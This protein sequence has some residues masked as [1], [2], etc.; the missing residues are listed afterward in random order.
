VLNLLAGV[1]QRRHVA[2]V[3]IAHDVALLGRVCE[4]LAVMAD[5]RL[6]EEG[7]S[8]TILRAPRHPETV[9]LLAAAGSAPAETKPPEIP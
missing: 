7:P 3:L 6:V 9:R 1:R 4:R 8:E 5:G 2:M